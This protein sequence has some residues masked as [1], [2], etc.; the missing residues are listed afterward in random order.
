MSRAS[1]RSPTRGGGYGLSAEVAKI[2]VAFTLTN[3]LTHCVLIS[4]LLQCTVTV[5]QPKLLCPNLV[6]LQAFKN[7]V[8]S[9]DEVIAW[10]EAVIGKAPL[11]RE[12]ETLGEALRSGEVLCHLVNKIKPESVTRINVSDM[13][14]K[15][16]EN[17]SAFLQ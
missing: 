1:S 9:E 10:I 7:D 6:L 3:S 12:D 5:I 11:V 2:Q 8:E 16:M 4:L 17:I 15:Q 14:F 13:P